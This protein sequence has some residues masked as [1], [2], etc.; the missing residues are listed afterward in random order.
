LRPSTEFFRRSKLQTSAKYTLLGDGGGQEF[1]HHSPEFG[2]HLII[3]TFT[4]LR[5][6]LYIR[7]G[8]NLIN[9]KFCA[10]FNSF[11]LKSL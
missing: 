6:I 2:L 1:R 7:W 4:L 11:L 5:R 8:F 3:P 9:L 10:F